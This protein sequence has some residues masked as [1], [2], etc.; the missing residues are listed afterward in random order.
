MVQGVRYCGFHHDG[1]VDRTFA[2][3]LMN[4]AV[5]IFVAHILEAGYTDA[6]AIPGRYMYLQVTLHVPA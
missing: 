3:P 4:S 5:L 6:P 1:A 2:V